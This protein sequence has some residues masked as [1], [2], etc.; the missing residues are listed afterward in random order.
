MKVGTTEKQELSLDKEVT[1]LI[2]LPILHGL[3]VKTSPASA[4]GNGMFVENHIRIALPLIFSKG[5]NPQLLES[6]EKSL[7]SPITK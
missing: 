2:K 1:Y 4:P 3:N 6:A 7:L 5:T